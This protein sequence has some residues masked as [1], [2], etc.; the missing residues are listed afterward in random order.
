MKAGAFDYVTKPFDNDELLLIINRA[1]D[2]HRLTAEV[3][4]L[5]QELATRYGFM[6][7]I[8]VSSPMREVFRVMDR[9]SATDVT[10]LIL[11]ESGTGKEL[12]ARGIHR[13][14]ARSTGPFVP[15]N[16]SA[17]PAT[18]IE[19]EFFGHERGAFT[20]ARESRPGKFEQ[21]HGGTLFLDEIGDLT[22]DAQSKLLRALE[23]RSVTRLG[24]ARALTVDVR[25]IAATNKSLEEAMRAGQFR[26]DLYWRLNVVSVK[27]PPLRERTED[28]PALIDHLLERITRE[29][30]L[31][32]TAVS[33][34]AMRLMLAY[35][36]PGNVRELENALRR[37]LV[38][39][40]GTT[41]LADD[42]PPRL[43]PGHERP[44][45]SSV[46]TR[47]PLTLAAAVSQATERVER[48][49]I[50]ATLAEHD[51]NRTATANTLGIN[52]KTLFNKMRQYDLG[53]PDGGSDELED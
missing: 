19:A 15:V 14:S 7:L 28:L 5:R 17:I 3:E 16:C 13:K 35:R 39:A 45:E 52:R 40:T 43:R 49:L 53:A 27:L 4:S 32:V 18:L 42:L 34:E 1:L 36:W 51:G 12:V 26:N 47:E 31:R 41:L 25:V 30:D 48:G 37:A 20:D 11:G 24:S 46:D 50:Q 9:V 29:F 22:L 23:D 8:G 44:G 21:A 38:L 6:D 33:G 2:L 10:V